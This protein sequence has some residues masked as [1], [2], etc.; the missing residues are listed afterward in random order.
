MIR[1][2][3]RSTLFPYTTLFRPRV[4]NVGVVPAA[5]PVLATVG[6]L[7]KHA[8]VRGETRRQEYRHLVDR[9]IVVGAEM[10][11]RGIGQRLVHTAVSALHHERERHRVLTLAE[12]I[13]VQLELAAVR[14]ERR[15]E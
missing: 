5:M 2:P 13:A 7:R 15:P 12:G 6:G 11:G 4:A 1:R 3:P 9:D 10:R 14:R 8:D